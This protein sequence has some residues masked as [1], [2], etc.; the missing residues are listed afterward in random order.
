[1]RRKAPAPSSTHDQRA[2]PRFLTFRTGKIVSWHDDKEILAAV[3]DIS[4]GG[5]CL[6]VSDTRDVPNRF[7][8]FA[9]RDC[10]IYR[11]EVRWKSGHKVGIRFI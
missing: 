9:D 11:C 10:D 6:L 8:F 7:Q 1:M 3:L 2:S 5:A 4:D